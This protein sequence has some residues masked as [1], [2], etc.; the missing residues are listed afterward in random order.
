L[1]RFRLGQNSCVS[2][3]FSIRLTSSLKESDYYSVNIG[4]A[5][6]N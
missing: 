5:K 1:L 6:T 4:K 3:R 2:A